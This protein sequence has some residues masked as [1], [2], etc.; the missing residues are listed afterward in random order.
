[1]AT[2]YCPARPRTGYSKSPRQAGYRC[3]EEVLTVDRVLAADE[4]WLTG[5]TKGI[6]PVVR[7]DE[8]SIGTGQPGPVWQAVNRTL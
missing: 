6:A 2:K 7:I 3:R 4:V 5:A 8:H 1:M